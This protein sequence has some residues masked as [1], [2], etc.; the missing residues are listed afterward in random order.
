M[1]GNLTTAITALSNS[2]SSEIAHASTTGDTEATTLAGIDTILSDHDVDQ[3]RTGATIAQTGQQLVTLADDADDGQDALDGFTEGNAD[4]LSD[5]QGASQTA[6]EELL[7]GLEATQT[8]FGEL[9]NGLSTDFSQLWTSVEDAE[10]QSEEQAQ[11]SSTE[12]VTL[13]TGACHWEATTRRAS[14]RNYTR[15]SRQSLKP[16]FPLSY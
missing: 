16:G 14:E 5:M 6:F 11:G 15:S 8:G 3:E 2:G 9:G 1:I 4:T 13:A 12:Y 7:D 10:D